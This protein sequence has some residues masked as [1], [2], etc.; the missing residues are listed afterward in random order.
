MIWGVH[1]GLYHLLCASVHHIPSESIWFIVVG[2]IMDGWILT[3]SS[4]FFWFHIEWPNNFKWDWQSTTVSLLE[5]VRWVMHFISLRTLVK[6]LLKI[7]TSCAITL[8][9]LTIHAH[10]KQQSIV[11]K[12]ER[13]GGYVR[14]RALSVPGKINPRHLILLF[15]LHR[16]CSAELQQPIMTQSTD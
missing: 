11:H 8:P 1:N 5:T 13:E 2:N 3:W 4:W 6:V 9:I 14:A 12:R 15:E 10:M 16:H 7:C